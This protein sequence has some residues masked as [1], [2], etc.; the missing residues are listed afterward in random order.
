M[1]LGRGA[2]SGADCRRGGSSGHIMP[3]RLREADRVHESIWAGGRAGIAGGLR[4]LPLGL[5]SHHG[6]PMPSRARSRRDRRPIGTRSGRAA[7]VGC[8]LRGMPGLRK[9]NAAHELVWAGR[10]RRPSGGAAY[11]RRLPGLRAGRRNAE[12][13]YRERSGRRYSQA[14]HDHSPCRYRETVAR[15]DPDAPPWI[16]SREPPTYSPASRKDPPVRAARYPITCP[17]STFRV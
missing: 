9:S 17:P 12:Q 6:L 5:R 15:A 14:L 4:R 13:S 11:R 7:G 2:A 3:I 16:I 8:A 10:R 1:R